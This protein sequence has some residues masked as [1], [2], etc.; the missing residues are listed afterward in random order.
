MNNIFNCPLCDSQVQRAGNTVSCRCGW[1]KSF[2]QVGMRK[3]QKSVVTLMLMAGFVFMGALVY[4]NQWGSSS[5]SIISLK[6]RQWTGSLDKNSHKRLVNICMRL[7]KYSCVEDAH[8]SY[9]RSS[10]DLSILHTLGEFQSR[11]SLMKSAG[12]TYKMYFDRK[13]RGVKPAYNYAQ[14][15]EKLGHTQHALNYYQYALKEKSDT[16]QI[17][18]LR[19]YIKL[20]VKEGLLVKARH[21]LKKFQSVIKRS[22]A[23]VQQEYRIWQ[24]QAQARS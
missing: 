14:I 16:I 20:L 6:A 5:F 12:N 3:I 2:N 17:S 7:K 24:K 9:Y 18:V 4:L 22:T 11:R 15:L 8:W 19:A 1:Y 10:Q 23:L 21:E 13:G